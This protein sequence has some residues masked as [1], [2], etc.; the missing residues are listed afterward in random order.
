AAYSFAG[1]GIERVF[2]MSDHAD[3]YQIME[4]VRRSRAKRVFTVHGYERELAVLIQKKL[5]VEAKPLSL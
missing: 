1:K 2:P 4:Y 5:G 3:Y